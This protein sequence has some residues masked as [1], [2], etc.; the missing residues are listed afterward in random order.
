MTVDPPDV[1][2]PPPA[3]ENVEV[4]TTAPVPTPFKELNYYEQKDRE[5]FAGREADS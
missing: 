3:N 1:A 2:T 4:N 5:R